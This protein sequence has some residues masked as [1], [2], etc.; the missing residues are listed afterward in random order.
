MNKENYIH[1]TFRNLD[2]ETNNG[3]RGNGTIMLRNDMDVASLNGITTTATKY[4]LLSDRQN[5]QIV[6]PDITDIFLNVTLK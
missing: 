6:M 4:F 1:E 3:N 5:T 2:E